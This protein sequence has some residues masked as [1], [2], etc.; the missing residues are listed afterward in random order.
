MYHQCKVPITS[1]GI[2]A[3]RIKPDG[4]PQYLMIRRK[5]TLGHIDFMRGKYSV[6]NRSYLLNM[7]NQM[8]LQEKERMKC[9]D[10][11]QL[12]KEIWGEH[13]ISNQYKMEESVSREKYEALFKG[14]VKQ[15][16]CF[17]LHDLIDESNAVSGWTE[18][19]WGFPK[20]RRNHQ[21]KDYECAIR[22]FEEETGYVR[23]NLKNV[24]N[25][26]PYEEIFIGS[27][28]KSYKHKYY[29]MKMDYVADEADAMNHFEQ[30]EVSKMDWKTHAECL[31]CIRDYNVEKKQLIDRVHR[32][33]QECHVLTL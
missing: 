4:T 12:W 31:E 29:L 23:R 10:F 6:C 17:T 25:I 22:E 26:V 33:I 21:E 7:L 18:A 20:G 16:S 28:Y 13:P 14:I 24:K 30:T 15:N 3:F 27:N 11:N 19:E 1:I 8:T 2:I 9:G 5:D 32:T